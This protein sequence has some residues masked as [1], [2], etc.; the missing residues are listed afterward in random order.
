MDK[1]IIYQ[2]TILPLTLTADSGI[3]VPSNVSSFIVPFDDI[4]IIRKRLSAK[5]YT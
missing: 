5:S 4:N 3:D 2:N 1:M